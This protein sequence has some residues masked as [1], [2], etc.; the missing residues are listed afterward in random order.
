MKTIIF[1]RHGESESNVT[2]IQANEIDKYPLTA[3]GRFQVERLTQELALVRPTALYSSPVL[4]AAETAGII[5]QAL[6]IPVKLNRALMERDWGRANGTIVSTFEEEVDLCLAADRYGIE[7]IASLT[8][9]VAEF[10]EGLPPGV[11]VAV[12][13]ADVIR[14]AVVHVLGINHDEFSSYGIVPE[15]ATMT[16]LKMRQGKFEV[17]AIGS[18]RATDAILRATNLDR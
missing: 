10:M 12:T 13:H 14:G 17:V 3:L 1:V 16:V 5:S 6:N 2:K 7:S 4:R 9:R 18:P 11:S 8:K 15:K